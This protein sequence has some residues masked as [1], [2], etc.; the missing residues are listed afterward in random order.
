MKFQ[1][2][3]TKPGFSKANK[4]LTVS[5]YTALL[6]LA[7]EARK[8]IAAKYDR[9][10]VGRVRVFTEPR[11][12][13]LRTKLWGSGTIKPQQVKDIQD[14]LTKRFPQ[15]NVEVHYNAT[16]EHRWYLDAL[17]IFLRVK[18]NT[19]P[20][21][22]YEVAAKPAP[23]AQKPKARLSGAPLIMQ[24]AVVDVATI[25]AGTLSI[26]TQMHIGVGSKTNNLEFELVDSWLLL[27]GEFVHFS[28]SD[29]YHNYLVLHLGRSKDQIYK[30][31][32]S[33]AEELIRK[34]VVFHGKKLFIG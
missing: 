15:L 24:S 7:A 9:L 25:P 8:M 18:P 33:A 11:K 32:S 14:M 4:S 17:S 1:T 16:K 29:P 13:G 19:W 30:D 5:E 34:S 31:A 28:D 22:E 3:H 21:S 23:V 2:S 26:E 6:G 20:I 12:G 10:S 27:N